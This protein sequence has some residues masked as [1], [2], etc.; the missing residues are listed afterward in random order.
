MR[1]ILTLLV[2]LLLPT[3][4]FAAHAAVK[5]A[6]FSAAQSLTAASSSP[7]NSYA[8]GA[9]IVLTAPVAGD[10][11][12]AAGSIITAAPVGGDDLFLAG[13]VSSRG[14][15]AGDLRAIGGNIEVDNSVGGDLFALAF[16]VQDDG[17]AGG[18]VFIVAA[19]TTLTDGAAG[20]VTIYGNNIALGGDFAG[21][22]TL[23]A[24]SRIVLA[25]DVRVRGKL[26]Y[27]APEAAVIPASAAVDGGVTYRNAS[28]LP[29]PGTSRVL[30]FI[31]IF[32]FI[33]ARIIGAI[34]LAGLLAGLFPQFAEMLHARGRAARPR[35]AIPTLLLGFAVSVATPIVI[36]VLML[37]LV[38]F[39]LAL[40]LIILY[41]LFVLLAFLYAGILIGGEFA[42][43]I[44]HREEILWH[45]GV[46]GMLALSVVTLVPF[47]GLPLVLLA[48]FFMLGLLLQVSFT[49]AF[50][51]DERS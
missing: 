1:T 27:S 6:S 38:G 45:D 40:L 26:S 49:F 5:S 14:N 36:L 21:D 32:F 15:V 50:P 44:A 25:P 31:S 10:F 37:T 11:S 51:H 35:S 22:V 12:A 9:S 18:S 3:S 4:A 42:R 28:Y 16:S 39:G 41:A 23:V 13:S 33:I 46:V 30:I 34:I 29:D 2:A 47:I 17:R 8:A 7:G 20:P 24:A 43:R 19:N 48:V